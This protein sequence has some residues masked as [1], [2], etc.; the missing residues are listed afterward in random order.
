MGFYVVNNSRFDNNGFSYGEEKGKVNTG[1]AIFCTECDSPLTMLEW[2]PPFEVKLSKG[3]LGDVI[4]GTYNHFIVSEKFKELYQ[5]NRF[6]GILTFE[7]VSLYQKGKPII[8]KYYCPK[9]G[10]SDVH[11]DIDKSGVVFD[12]IEECSTCQKAGRVIKKINGLYINSDSRMND[13]IFCTMM[14]PGDIIFS[15]RFKENAK[16]LLNLSFIQAEHY[17]PSWVVI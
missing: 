3:Q 14:L 8:D 5:K 6:T 12:G 13:D 11:I 17:V 9:I 7:P 2:L 10:L 16:D 1:D 4:F 15:E